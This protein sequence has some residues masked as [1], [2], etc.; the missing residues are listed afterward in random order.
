[1]MTTW[2]LFKVLRNKEALGWPPE[3]VLPIFY[4]NGRIDPVPAHYREIGKIMKVWQKA[5]GVI[6]SE[7]IR[8]GA[9]LAIEVGD[10]FEEL[11]AGSLQIEG[12]GVGEAPSGSDCG[13]GCADGADR[14]REGMRVF[15]VLEPKDAV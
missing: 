9:T 10:T 11:V 13:V 14:F 7:P 12:Q 6:P 8:A 5:F 4:R 3:V 15:L 1:L 2:D